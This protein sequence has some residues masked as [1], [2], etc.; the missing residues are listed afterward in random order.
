VARRLPLCIGSSLEVWLV[1]GL[2]DLTFDAGGQIAIVTRA[3]AVRRP[4]DRDRHTG[5]RRAT[6]AQP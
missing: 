6:T 5:R 1:G 4:P 3:D 2:P